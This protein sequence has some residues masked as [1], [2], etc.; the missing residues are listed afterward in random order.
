VPSPAE[1][2]IP[3]SQ[4]QQRIHWIRGKRV[5]LDFDL[6]RLYGV[7]TRVLLQAV[8]RNASRFP[9]DFMFQL[10]TITWE[11]LR[12]QIV[13]SKPGRGGRRYL[14]KAFTEQG[15]AMLSSVLKSESA[16]EINIAIMRAFVRLREL[17]G[18]NRRLAAKLT[19]L[20]RKLVDH[21][22][23]IGNLFEAI[24]QL[25]ASPGPNHRRKIGFHRG[26]R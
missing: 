15:V 21:D 13:I 3:V 11:G 16:V 22:A 19:E 12:S 26:N 25:L 24:R 6:A 20:E 1:L 8:R 4:I 17:L 10:S 23:A 5:M 18:N 14:P 2:L 9:A 7:D